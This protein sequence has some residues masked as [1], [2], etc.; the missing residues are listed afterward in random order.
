MPTIF[1]M[2]HQENVQN[3]YGLPFSDLTYPV[4]L[5]VS[6]VEALTV[7]SSAAIGMIANASNNYWM[8]VF[9][10]E[11]GVRIYVANNGIPSL[12]TN[13]FALGGELNPIT[14]L[15]KGGDVLRFITPDATAEVSVSF[16][17]VV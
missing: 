10:Y 14:K 16:Y 5:L 13:S 1:R 2:N 17:S 8:A 15:V 11:P 7:P 9:S 3:G 4:Q 6:T 12:P